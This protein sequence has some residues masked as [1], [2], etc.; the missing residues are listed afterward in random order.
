MS[1]ITILILIMAI[2]MLRDYPEYI[3]TVI[4]WLNHEFG[5][6]NSGNFY[7]GIIEH[8]LTEEQTYPQG[9]SYAIIYA[10]TTLSVCSAHVDKRV[11]NAIKML[12][13]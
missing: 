12:I 2:G 11:Q 5:N 8:S 9:F 6:E 3:D 10:V 4:Q 1:I 7:K 13:L